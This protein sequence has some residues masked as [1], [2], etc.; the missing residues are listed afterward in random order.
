MNRNDIFCSS[1]RVESVE[2][3]AGHS[4]KNSSHCSPRRRTRYA[5]C[6]ALT[7]ITVSP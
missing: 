4:K 5:D 2:S 6:P 3:K 1:Y 7:Q